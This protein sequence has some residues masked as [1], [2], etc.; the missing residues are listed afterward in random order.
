MPAAD[1]RGVRRGQ[2]RAGRAAGEQVVAVGYLAAWRLVRLLPEPAAQRVFARVADQLVRRDGRGVAR[3]RSNLRRLRPDLDE[4]GLDRLTHA[5]A[6]SYLRYWC[7]LFRL[8][9]WPLPDLVARTR[10][11]A[12]HH[13]RDAYAAGG[14][15]VVALPHMANWD[16]A[17]A[18][19]CA[20]GMP[21]ATVAERLRP[22][23]L[24]DRFVAYRATLGMRILPLTGGAPSL[25]RLEEWVR[26]GGLVCLLADRDLSRTGVEV[27]LCGAR[28]RVPRGPAVLALRTGAPLVPVTLHYEGAEMVLAFHP[29]VPPVD[30]PAGPQAMMQG[31]ADAF[32]E[33]LRAH[34]QDWHMMQRV[35]VD[36]PPGP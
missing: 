35:F 14:G 24:Y 10:T 29:P 18:W 17:G 15:A 13:L 27:E 25:P 2:A 4:A 16:W 19:A 34:P 20:T 9:S 21:L 12:E 33:G 7:E 26:S 11:E 1:R 23:R 36:E 3:L 22:E 8:P 31:V 30:G 28:A 6:R 5:A 32:T